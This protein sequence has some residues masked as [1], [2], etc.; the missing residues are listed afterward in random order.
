M[1]SRT[2]AASVRPPRKRRQ[3]PYWLL[4]AILLALL[5]IWSIVVNGDYAVIFRALRQGVLVTLWVSVVSFLLA[6][7]LGLAIALARVS[8]FRLLREA[9]TFYI[10]IVR[11]IPVLVLLWNW[12][13]EPLI[14][15]GWLPAANVRDFDMAWR[16]VAALAI[17]YAAFVAEIFRAGIESVPRGQVEAARSLGLRPYRIYRHVIL[18]QALRNAVPPLG[19]D[20]VAL[21]KDS[22]LVSALGVQDITQLGKVYS[23]S[24]FL[25]FETYNVV[26]FLYLVM[27]VGLSLIVRGLESRLKK[28][29][30]H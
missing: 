21:I 5:A 18:P 23:S 1:R 11:G 3:I 25:F 10:E 8:R 4:A 9:A 13:F 29:G 19:N 22:A 20:L 16:A 27:T 7:V 24:T 6:V 2:R 15:P 30:R 26:A 12:F 14:A 28:S 17:S